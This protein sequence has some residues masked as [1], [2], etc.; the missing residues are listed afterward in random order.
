MSACYKP[1]ASIT[2]EKFTKTE[3]TFTEKKKKTGKLIDKGRH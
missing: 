1:I 3:R 2:I